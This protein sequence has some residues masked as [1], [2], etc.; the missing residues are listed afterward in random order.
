MLDDMEQA[1]RHL[2]ECFALDR[3]WYD[4]HPDT[5]SPYEADIDNYSGVIDTLREGIARTL[6]ELTVT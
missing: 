3:R 2:S 5:P 1:A 6:D 4:E